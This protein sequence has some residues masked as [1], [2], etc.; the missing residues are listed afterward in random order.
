MSELIR[1]IAVTEK[2][3]GSGKVYKIV[4][5]E[6]GG[7]QQRVNYWGNVKV[8][9]GIDY[10][11]DF[12]RD[13]NDFLVFET[14]KLA[15]EQR[16]LPPPAPAVAA[17]SNG[18]YSP[19]REERIMRGNALNAAAAALG[20]AIALMWQEAEA[21]SEE[22]RSQI[23]DLLK[24]LATRLVPFLRGD[25]LPPVGS[26]HSLESPQHAA[27]EAW[28]SAQEAA[29]GPLQAKLVQQPTV[30]ATTPSAP[31]TVDQFLLRLVSLKVRNFDHVRELLGIEDSLGIHISN[32]LDTWNSL[33]DKLVIKVNEADE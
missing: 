25:N 12:D 15:S 19:E 30:P 1:P 18:Y 32:G 17:A 23:A 8:A 10:E 31:M 21:T 24:D 11:A 14:I 5:F 16:E 9:A 3:S 7:K 4:E 26:E 6:R 22:F 27:S 2:V 28:Q 20:P 29:D 13:K 33:Y